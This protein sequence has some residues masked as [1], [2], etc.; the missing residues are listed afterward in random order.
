MSLLK[1]PKDISAHEL[2][3]IYT[4][5]LCENLAVTLWCELKSD[6]L[7]LPAPADA[8]KTD[9][10]LVVRL[11]AE[12]VKHHAVKRLLVLEHNLGQLEPSLNQRDES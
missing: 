2:S 10:C 6:A 4:T 8:A 9:A 1:T 12:E 7:R 3:D 5:Q 11:A